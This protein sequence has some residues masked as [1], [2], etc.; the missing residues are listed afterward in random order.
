MRQKGFSL[1]E[2]LIVVAIILTIAAIAIPN[3]IRSKMVANEASAANSMRAI[4]TAQTTYMLTYPQIGYAD[5]LTKLGAPA[6]NGPVS[7]A[8]AGILDFV[9]G[10]TSQPCSKHGY[11]FTIVNSSGSPTITSFTAAGTPVLVGQSGQR[12]FCIDQSNAILTDA[13]GGNNCTTP[14]Q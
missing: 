6:G 1:I 2:L 7:S 14:L 3:F 13:A 11:N 12:G 9:L 4:G 10:C 5:N 8:N